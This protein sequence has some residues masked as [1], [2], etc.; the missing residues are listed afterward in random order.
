VAPRRHRL[1]FTF[2]MVLAMAGFLAIT[3][4]AAVPKHAAGSAA[5]VPAKAENYRAELWK[6]Y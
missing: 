6:I 2:A 5:P 3:T 1:A 4:W